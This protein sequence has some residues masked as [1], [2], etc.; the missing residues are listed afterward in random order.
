MTLFKKI[1]LCSSAC[2]CMAPSSWAAESAGSDIRGVDAAGRIL[3]LEVTITKGA[4]GGQFVGGSGLA[5]SGQ[6]VSDKDMTK[7]GST[8]ITRMLRSVPGVNIQEEDGFGLRPNIGLRGGRIDRS[9][10]LTLM[11]DGVLIAPAPYAAPAAYYFPKTQRMDGIEV[12]KGSST[13]KYG[14][15]TTNGAINLLTRPVPQVASGEVSISGGSYEGIRSSARGGQTVHTKDGSFGAAVEYHHESSRGFKDPDYTGVD[16]GFNVSDYQ[17]KLDYATPDSYDLYQEIG[18]KFGYTD[19]DS[20]ETYLGLTNADFSANPYRRYAASAVDNMDA[21]HH[22]AQITHYMEPM[23]GLDVTTTVYRTDF[24]RNWYKLNDVRAGTN[25]SIATVL[26]DPTTFAAHLAVLRGGNSAANGLTVRAN[27]RDY[28]AHG[29]QSAAK[30]QFNAYGT[31]NQLEV[32]LRYHEDE[33]DRYQHDDTYQMIGGRMVLTARGAPGS[34]SNRVQTGKAWAGYVTNRTDFGQLAVSPGV[35][36]EYIDLETDN[37]GGADPTRTGANLQQFGST[38]TAIVPGVGVEYDLNENVQFIAGVHKGFAPPEPP[39]NANNAANAR[40]EE[41]INYEAGAR[42]KRGSVHAEVI[43]FYTDY[44]NLLGAD[45]FSG[46]GGGAGDQFNGGEVDVMGLEAG[47]GADAADLFEPLPVKLPVNLT[48]TLTDT[49]FKNSFNSSFSEWGNVRSGD[50]LPYVPKHQIS[51][52]AGV[53]GEKWLFSANA[54]Y[55]DQMRTVAGSGAL[56]EGINSTDSHVT[57]DIYGEYQLHENVIPYISATNI[58]DEEYIAA[59]RP[60]G[61]RPGAPAM[62][63]AGVKFPLGGK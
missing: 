28:F 20:N 61:L 60:A 44:E 17:L 62:V 45:T 5:G 52:T 22:Q 13:V 12:R 56:V 30:Y 48:Y 39:T 53:E 9:A 31:Q 38:I 23:P 47:I 58:L 10:D 24:N 29:V 7:S 36:Y 3:P 63:Y 42:F 35:R 50:E 11:E 55:T 59:A 2:L 18:V 8:D 26:N 32:G 4:E 16:T 49:E 46:G 14:P 15:R 57:V 41:S 34:Q 25:Q 19:Q 43:G 1:F 27:N 51:L 6:Y 40:E 33:M 21:Y 37:Y 54:K